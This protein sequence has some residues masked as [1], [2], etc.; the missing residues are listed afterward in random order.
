MT[1]KL[2]TLWLILACAC[3]TRSPSQQPDAGLDAGTLPDAGP[4]PD[5]GTLPDGGALPVTVHVRA[6]L[7]GVGPTTGGGQAIVSGSGFVDGF[8]QRGGGEVTQKTTLTVGGAPATALEVI[9]DNRI[10]LTLP[11]GQAGPADVTVTNPNGSGTCA[12]CFRYVT[13]VRVLS[14]SPA[15][16]PA[17]GGTAVT[18]KGQG[19]TSDTLLTLGGR[20]L[21]G[22]QVAD[23]QTITG[24]TPP[25]AAG[26]AS[27]LA[28][29]RDGRDERRSAFVYLDALRVEFVDPGVAA[30]AGGTRLTI[31]GRGFSPQAQVTIDGA[32][33]PT[34]WLDAGH[35]SAVAPAHAAGAVDVT[36][37]DPQALA[38]SV[39]LPRGLAYVDAGA[40]FA[41]VAI[42]PA[43]GPLAG[44]VCPAACVRLLGSG[45]GA[46]TQVLIGGKPAAQHPR[47]DRQL[48]V[49]LPPGAAP[50][51]V[52][53]SVTAGGVQQTLA[54][55]FRYDALSVLSI[56]PSSGPLAGGTAVTVTGAGLTADVRVGASPLGSAQVSPDQT[57]LTGTT[58]PGSP[59]L[60]DVVAR[61]GDVEARLPAAFLYAAPLAVAQVYPALGAQAGGTRVSILG[62]G[63]APG[64]T[65]SIGGAPVTALALVSPSEVT[66]LTPP[67]APGLARVS[68]SLAGATAA[69]PGGFTYFDPASKLGGGT[70]GPLLGVLNV[71]VLEASA[72]K[73]GGVPGATVTVTLHDGATLQALTD[74]R[75]QVTFSDERLVL[76]ATV[77]ADKPPGYDAVTVGAVQTAN[78]TVYLSGPPGPPPPPP[79]PPPP[80]P[81]PL[82][83]ASIGGHVYG[84]KLPPSTVLTPSQRQV[85]RVYIARRD[86]T[87]LPPFSPAD[88][89]FVAVATDGGTFNFPKLYSLDPTTLYAVFGIEDS[90][91]TPPGFEPVLLGILRAVQ[92]N[93]A[94]PITNADIL[95][96]THLDQS[97]DVTVTGLPSPSVGHDAAVDLDLGSGGVIPLAHVVQGSDPSHLRFTHLPAAAGQGFVFVDLT[98]PWTGS[99]ITQPVSTYL[100]RVFNDLSSGVTLGP[101]LSFPVPAA[102]ASP[103]DGRLAWTVPGNSTLQANLQ[104]VR[105]DDVSWQVVLPGD[106]RGVLMPPEL[107]ALLKPGVH[108]WSIT[109]S[110][111]PGFDFAHWNFDDLYSGA[112]TAYAYA[113]G[114]FTTAAP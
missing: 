112:W 23:A 106:A 34:G 56:A 20:E 78:L 38:P 100:R 109:T 51:L 24:L 29:T 90:S 68:V 89:G 12:G 13:P 52:D 48:D 58:G 16:G 62:R 40:P 45:L 19:F 53:V 22:V 65:V 101:L 73:K 14:I 44:G 17:A 61:S 83:P 105:V 74:A 25:G 11:A 111:A 9:D 110:V 2:F 67:G 97:V 46:A 27:L 41:L 64:L 107:R 57:S 3:G 55:A 60:A 35:L 79:D 50:G 63:F 43:H 6:I 1:R 84:F 31:S 103:F 5:G 7:P 94:T 87:A 104:Q 96:D 86:V 77:T 70:G 26:P 54:Q 114:S 81:P 47:D 33:A 99:A 4:A 102:A 18:V 85:A 21:I 91:T 66:G 76:P 37:T 28:L 92:P 15:S 39:T 80:P 36:V 95:L 82:Q 88:R 8:A 42:E 93:P 59:G 69:L 75:G 30:T 32:A 108:A 72:Y 10:E 49:D 98:G 71:S 113:G